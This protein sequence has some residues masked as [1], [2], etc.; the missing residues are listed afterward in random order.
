M[1]D[2]TALRAHHG[3]VKDRAILSLFEDEGRAGAFS[4]RACDMLFD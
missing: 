3:D 2:W 1:A 4:V